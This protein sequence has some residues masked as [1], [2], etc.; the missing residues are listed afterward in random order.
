MSITYR[1]DVSFL[2]LRPFD[3]LFVLLDDLGLEAIRDAFRIIDEVLADLNLVHG[4]DQASLDYT[5][6]QM[7]INL[8]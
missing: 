8:I 7:P 2:S 3:D 1:S 4:P 5:V 6:L